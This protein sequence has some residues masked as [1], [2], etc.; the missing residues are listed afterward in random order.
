MANYDSRAVANSFIEINGEEISQMK[1]QKLIFFTCGWHLA[2]HKTSLIN[3]EFE[4]WDGGPVIRAL[5]NHLRDYKCDKKT[6]RLVR[7]G[8]NK[9]YTTEMNRPEKDIIE[10]VWEKYGSFTGKDL[11]EMTHQ[12]GSPWYVAYIK[13]GRN[14]IIKNT[15]IS[16]YFTRLA[17]AGRE[18]KEHKS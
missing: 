3:D 15:V 13:S 7:P 5:W 11:S 2:I 10:K 8:T 9:P 12:L 4:A 16:D 1:L 6:G 14:T 17:L 18:T